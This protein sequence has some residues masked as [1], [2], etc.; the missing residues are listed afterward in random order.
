MILD[1]G[2]FRNILINEHLKIAT[3]L[4]NWI[5]NATVA[6]RKKFDGG[7]TGQSTTSTP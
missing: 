5:I 2:L 7:V 1:L 4:K 3:A 6:A